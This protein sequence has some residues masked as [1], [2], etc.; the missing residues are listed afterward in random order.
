QVK[1]LLEKHKYLGLTQIFIARKGILLGT[2]G[3][4]NQERPNLEHLVA[5]LKSGGVE[6]TA[7]ITGDARYTAL[8]MAARL[9]FDECRYSVL[10]AEKAD[11]IRSLRD[12]GD[13]IL[14][15]GDGINDALALAEADIGVAMGTGGSEV[16]IEA[17]D[18]ALVTDDLAGVIYVRE[19]SAKTLSVV[20]QNFWIATGSN[21][22]G[23]V[24]GAA[25]LLSPV[26]AGLVHI[27][28]TLGILAN[29]SRL[30]FF[31]IPETRGPAKRQRHKPNDT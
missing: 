24:L 31:D 20:H 14:M 2:M 21:I 6:K 22:G 25:G 18:I 4:A 30:L 23:V 10:P 19:L 8:E 12:D 1:T 5:R 15:V 3:F 26:M 7:M 11:I 9:K 29:S 17:A 13:R 27:L 16:A 28:H